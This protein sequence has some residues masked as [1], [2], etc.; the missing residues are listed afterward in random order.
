MIAMK[1]SQSQLVDEV[2]HQINSRK[3]LATLLNR[4][5]YIEV[6]SQEMQKSPHALLMLRHL[7]GSVNK[8]WIGMMTT[9][10]CDSRLTEIFGPNLGNG[11][12]LIFLDYRIN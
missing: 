6:T 1:Q 5:S 12:K 10:V 9:Q 7:A 4:T 8:S 11:Q 3:H 2:G